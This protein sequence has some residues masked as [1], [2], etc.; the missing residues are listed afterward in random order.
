M[1]AF[2]LGPGVAIRVV[3]SMLRIQC[4]THCTP[5][6]LT[7]SGRLA[8]DNVSEL[9]QAL[10]S[11]PTGEAVVLD[12]GDLILA[13]REAVRF[14]GEREVAGR[15]VL[16]NCPAYIPHVDGR[17]GQQLTAFRCPVF[18]HWR[19]LAG[20]RTIE[21]IR[22]IGAQADGRPA[23][24]QQVAHRGNG[25]RPPVPLSRDP[26]SGVLHGEPGIALHLPGSHAW[27]RRLGPGT[28]LQMI[29]VDDIGW[30]G[31]RAFTDGPSLNRREIDL[32]GDIRT[33]S[34]AAEILTEAL[35][36]PI[37]SRRRQS[38]RSG[39]DSKDTALMLE[40]FDR[41]GYSADIAGLEREFGRR[42][43]EAPRLG[44]PPRGVRARGAHRTGSR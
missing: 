37:A 26:A 1:Q 5:I 20:R 30:F 43:H 11:V 7:I 35:G 6:V 16:R 29:A 34:E 39:S 12:L 40:W 8:A 15:I 21:H 25:A 2:A 42:A 31:A 28:N 9:R 18:R 3:K 38:N 23:L 14:L 13:D 41:V 4:T 27:L 33:M 22:G 17:R 44:T 24:R 10:D 32:A 19:D 36:R